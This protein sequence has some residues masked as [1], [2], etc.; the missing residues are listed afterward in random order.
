MKKL[1]FLVA[2]ASLFA[3]VPVVGRLGAVP[4]SVAIVWLGILAAVCASGSIQSLAIAIGALGAFGGGVLESSSP[5]VAGAVFVA[6]AFAERTMRVRTRGNRAL[7]VLL[8]LVGGALAGTLSN[9]YQ[10]A[11][12]AVFGVAIV[13]AAIL[14]ALPLIVEADDPVAHALEEAAA[15]V[16]MPAKGALVDGAALRRQSV[17]IPLDR[18]TEARVKTTWKS[19]L[20][21]A[22]ARIRLER[23][24][25]RLAG[26][27]HLASPA[28]TSGASPAT[29]SGAPSPAAATA[30]ASASEGAPSTTTDA[31][32]EA[33]ASA[34]GVRV[35]ADVTEGAV[36]SATAPKA[37][38]ADAVLTMVDQRIAEHV[39]VLARAY[40]AVDAVRAATIG[41]DDAALK[42]VESMGD[43]L[44]EVSRAMVEVREVGRGA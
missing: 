3:I 5:T 23:S 37:N 13:V 7:H 43:S 18:A 16:S 26:L 21:L 28:S 20:R 12:L 9:A 25:P 15:M 42:N 6:A 41:I 1:A 10:G 27:G 8:A 34:E 17:E 24:R 35:S 4:S 32:S 29:A 2:A 39:S 22:E 14:A 36:A 44:E 31:P 19:L 38:P 40:T 33:T 11:S 30:S